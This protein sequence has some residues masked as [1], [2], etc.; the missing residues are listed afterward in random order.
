MFKIAFIL[1]CSVFA[2]VP[3]AGDSLYDEIYRPQF[4]FS[5]K[6]NWTND[7]NGLVYYAGTWHLFF[8]HN[9]KG[10]EWGNMTWGH[11][12]S[13]DLV[14]WTEHGFAIEPDETGTIFSG[15]AVV[16]WNNTSG[17]Q[18]GN[19]KVLIAFYT[20]A[21]EPFTQCLAYSNDAGK[22]W[23]KYEKNPIIG[24]IAGSN[25]DPKVIWHE[26]SKKWV[27][28][29]FLIDNDFALFGS[30][31]LTDWTMLQRFTIEGSGECPDFFPMH[32]DGDGANVKWAFIPAD[33]DYLIG[34]F[35]GN[36][37]TPEQKKQKGDWGKNFYAVQ[38][39][40][41][42]P[43]GRRIQ[44]AWMRGGKYPDMPFNQ[45]MS[46]PCELTLR[47]FPE[48]LRICRNPVKEIELLRY[49]SQSWESLTLQ[50]GDNPLAGVA[51]DLF[52]IRAELQFDPAN[53]PQEIGFSLRG[54]K[55]N[56]NPAKKE[57]SC[58]G[59][60]A[61]V[62]APGGKL[63]LQILLDRTTVET[64]GNGGKVSMSSCFLPDP[65]NKQ[66][67][68]YTVGAPVVLEKLEVHRLKSGWRK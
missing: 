19:E 57:L 4:H 54:E 32:V 20:A 60:T 37:F 42:A 55:V 25:R 38:T 56:Y 8:Q 58:L 14:H 51:G 23:V 1:S 35:D 13:P 17:L 6:K 52:D 29:L 34:S 15:S 67:A 27:M 45:Q 48:G 39:Y 64:F 33:G 50:P 9:P 53:P 49:G 44:I 36:T 62:E 11:A 59:A 41:D 68:A 21:G 3:A 30:K 2:A 46:F 31:N 47:S 18:Q 5:P 43:D 63:S 16:D 26:P 7:P 40:S 61:P 65:A 10:R 24:H 22:T 12:T 66:L 28:A